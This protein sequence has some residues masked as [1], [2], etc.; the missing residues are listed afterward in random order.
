M[1]STTND[2]D[3]NFP[4]NITGLST[5]ALTSLSID[6]TTVVLGDLF[7]KVTDD[8]DDIKNEGTTN[9]W[10]SAI[11]VSSPLTKTLYDLGIQIGSALQ[12]GAISASD[13][14]IFNNKQNTI[15]VN[16]PL[17]KNVDTLSINP[18]GIAT[19][20]Y[21]TSIKFNYWNAKQDAM[22]ASLPISISGTNIQMTQSASGTNG[23]LSSTDWNTFNNKQATISCSL[24]LSISGN[25][26][27]QTQAS[28]GANGWL[29]STDWSFFNTSASNWTL[30]GGYIRNNP[31]YHVYMQ[32]GTGIIAGTGNW[33]ADANNNHYCQS[34][35]VN[36]SVLCDVSRNLVGAISLT[37]NGSS[38][39]DSSRNLTLGAGTITTTGNVTSGAY[40][41]GS[42]TL[43][44]A[45]RNVY[46]L[47]L[48]I[49][50]STA[51]NSSRDLFC[52]SINCDQTINIGSL[53]YGFRI[54]NGSALLLN[55]SCAL[56]GVYN[57][58]TTYN[59]GA[60]MTFVGVNSGYTYHHSGYGPSNSTG[61]GFSS[62]YNDT[63]S[64]N[65]AVGSHSGYSNQNGAYNSYLGG[66][67]GYTNSSGSWNT[68]MGQ[69]AL[70]STGP[71]CE[72]NVSIGGYSLFS[73]YN[74]SYNTIIGYQ[75]YMYGNSSPTYNTCLGYQAQHN[76][77]GYAVHET[78][79]IGTRA[80]Y[81][82]TA[83]YTV[84][85]GGNACYNNT[86]GTQNTAIGYNSLYSVSTGFNN[87]AVGYYAGFSNTGNYN[88]YLG[89]LAGVN[90]TSG[91]YNI[92]VGVD[93]ARL[94]GHYN[95][96][97]G[98]NVMNALCYGS[99]N[100]AIGESCFRTT[101]SSSNNVVIGYVAS[102]VNFNGDSNVFLGYGSNSNSGSATQC[103][104]VG[105]N[106]VNNNTA[107]TTCLGG[108][109]TC[110]ANFQCSLGYNSGPQHGGAN[111]AYAYF[112]H[113]SISGMSSGSVLY[114]DAFGRWGPW[115]SARRYKKNIMDYKA[116]KDVLALRVV[117]YNSID[118]KENK[119]NCI[120]LIAEEVNELFPELVPKTITGECQSVN[121]PLVS[122]LLL[123]KV[124]QQQ[125]KINDQ[126]ERIAKLEAN[127]AKLMNLFN[128]I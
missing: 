28:S 80:C 64:Y 116:E 18:A 119:E 69:Y 81:R 60:N 103:V 56:V 112:V 19:D 89:C 6:G 110:T 82:N 4:Y 59:L 12:S 49:N 22:S 101:N 107:Y 122:V 43:S 58:S 125:V 84:A 73:T 71:A 65:T 76:N 86:S 72:A 1:T 14:V 37:I 40:I 33:I 78:V 99:G 61:V 106:T 115:V 126:A 113:P 23:W 21:T 108:Y 70:Y 48:T 42:Y 75:A 92:S 9:R 32:A 31:S 44:D 96:C 34:L 15:L 90:A 55:S 79:S 68:C 2:S 97:M 74:P 93:N 45:S 117:R 95:I 83:N 124:K 105:C 16:A 57:T 128:L 50:G 53:T 54:N 11:T 46:A 29:S 47:S 62:L 52:N 39:I 13:W 87:T 35:Y 91:T 88:T 109:S 102:A 104:A 8:T 111:N 63:A 100:V 17:V 30:S 114:V 118:D 127:V 26:I 41:V 5:L 98:T 123:E 51:F 7:N 27:S 120:G 3:M 24:P 38:C 20:G 10:A 77:G 36:G 67:C 121:Y 66:L 85:I 94:S 25:N